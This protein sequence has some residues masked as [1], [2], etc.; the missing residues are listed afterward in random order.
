MGSVLVGEPELI[1]KAR[2]LP[3]ALG[4]GLRQIGIIAAAGLYALE[5]NVDRLATDHANARRLA[6][7]FGR[8]GALAATAPDTNIVWVTV[9][10]E[11]ARAYTDFLA[12]EGFGITGGY[13]KAQQRWVTHLDV[14]EA[15]IDR[16]IAAAERY[17]SSAA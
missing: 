1:S 3:K 2:R 13:G 12:A 8:I 14:D 11:H 10:P 9:A 17:F 7:G 6:E 15:A 5:H 4:G 16:A